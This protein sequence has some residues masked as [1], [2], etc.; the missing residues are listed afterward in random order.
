MACTHGYSDGH[1]DEAQHTSIGTSVFQEEI[2][3]VVLGF[4]GTPREMEIQN[5][6]YPKFKKI[7]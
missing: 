4:Q 7:S 3:E 5:R 1:V 2:W 6:E